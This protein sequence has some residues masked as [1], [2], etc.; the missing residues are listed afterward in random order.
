MGGYGSGRWRW[1][2]PKTRVEQCVVIDAAQWQREGILREGSTCYRG[3]V[4]C[5]GYRVDTTDMANPVVH[6]KY[7]LSDGH[8]SGAL[9]KFNY[10]VDLRTTRPYFGGLRWW[11]TCPLCQRRAQK[12]YRPPFGDHFGCRHCYSLSYES[13]SYSA[14]DRSRERAQAVRLR[15]GGSASLLDPFPF[16]PRGMWG[17]T[18]ER[19][20]EH[21][22][23]QNTIAWSLIDRRLEKR[24]GAL[25]SMKR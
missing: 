25:S 10:R 1:H 14:I 13:R 5:V 22:H 18:Y 23:R 21:Y 7:T 19:L 11:F 2:R 4:F 6:L 16:K 9:H 24:W 15:L 20:Q 8:A 17:K 3:A 12:L